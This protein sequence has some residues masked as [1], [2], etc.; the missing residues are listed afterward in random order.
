M[1][2]MVRARHH[3]DRQVLRLRPGQHVREQHGRILL[4]MD[5]DRIGRHRQRFQVLHREAHQHH[6]FRLHALGEPGLD[7]RTEGKTGEHGLCTSRIGNDGGE[8]FELAA[9]FVVRS[10]ARADAAEIWPP[11][12]VAE[13]DEGARQRLRDLVVQGA[14]EQRVRVRDDSHA[15]RRTGFRFVHRAFNFSRRP[16]D[17]LAPGGGSHQMRSLSTMR[18]CRRCSST[19]S[20]MSAR[21]T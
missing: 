11:G 10:L 16:R 9:P 5:Q 3:G 19:I 2:E 14:A 8:V 15:A 17:Q 7:C 4:A 1:E 20:S 13:F 21:S 12:A 18:P 6:A